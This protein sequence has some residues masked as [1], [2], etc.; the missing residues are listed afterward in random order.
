MEE[1]KDNEHLYK[2]L[3]SILKLFKNRPHHLAKYLIE[4]EAFNSNFIM[5]LIDSYKLNEINKEESKTFVKSVYF[6][7]ISQMKDYFNSFTDEI[8]TKSKSPSIITKELNEKLDK[9]IKEEK[10]EDAIRI[11]DYM[12]KNNIERISNT[13][14]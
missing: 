2:N 3:I 14:I 8:K 9:F 1:F 13:D 7:D 6:I 12:N 11:R 10:Y 5:K 4:N